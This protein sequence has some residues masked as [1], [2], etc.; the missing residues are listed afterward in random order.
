MEENS[1]KVGNRQDP[2]QTHIPFLFK[3]AHRPFFIT[4]EPCDTPH[5]FKPD[6][7]SPLGWRLETDSAHSAVRLTQQTL[8]FHHYFTQ[9]TGWVIPIL[10][11]TSGSAGS[12]G[13]RRQRSR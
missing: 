5:V 10:R 7:E 11:C 4:S 9:S 3:P 12:A 8:V 1:P 2:I 13:R 6:G